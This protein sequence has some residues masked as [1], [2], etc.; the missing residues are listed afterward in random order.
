ML[1]ALDRLGWC[2]FFEDQLPGKP[3]PSLTPARIL[4]DL[5][6]VCRVHTGSEELDASIRGK[7]FHEAASREALPVTGDWVLI[8]RPRNTVAALITQ[9]LDRRTRLARK[10]AGRDTTEQV[11][12]AN[13]DTVLIVQSLDAD[14]NERRL[15]RY[16]VAVREGG[17]RPV[18]VLNK[19]D[20]CIEGDAAAKAELARRV[21]AGAD[22]H[23]LG[24]L[25]NKNVEAVATY[26]RP[27]ETVAL[28][29]SSGVGKS[30]LLNRLAGEELQR[31]RAVRDHDGRGRHTTTSRR[32]VLLDGGG[33]ILDTPG[34]RELA[35][36]D[37]DSG[38]EASFADIQELARSCRFRDCR[39]EAEPG[40]A[41]RAAV[42]AGTLD[43]ER[44]ESHRKLERESQHAAIKHDAKLKSEQTLEWRRIHKE[45]RRMYR[46]KG[47]KGP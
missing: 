23:V 3:D 33:L 5:G 44:I 45:Q 30:T 4:E 19:E 29:G 39:H 12:A 22:V 21:A 16:L 42:V 34:I 31:V 37:A 18:V 7:L 15:E 9:V 35:L 24:A 10:A 1:I 40:C 38:L 28:V 11:L 20:L 2:K 13:V 6:R 25:D 46:N 17:A 32:L 36:L 14:F 47:K 43:P 27:G 41:V 8:R 26:F